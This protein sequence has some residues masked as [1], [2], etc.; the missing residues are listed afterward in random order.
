M[1]LKYSPHIANAKSFLR[2]GKKKKVS[3]RYKK[4]SYIS[5]I[6]PNIFEC[7]IFNYTDNLKSV[8]FLLHHDSGFDQMP[9][10]EITEEEYKLLKSK[11]IPISNCTNII[12]DELESFECKSGLCPIK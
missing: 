8:S 5:K 10:E 12:D 6:Q 3:L 11:T 9:Y 1:P 7:Y 2:N 4:S